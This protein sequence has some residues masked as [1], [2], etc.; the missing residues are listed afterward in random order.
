MI[1]KL[2]S[3]VSHYLK[4]THSKMD[5][6]GVMFLLDSTYLSNSGRALAQTC[7]CLAIAKC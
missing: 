5:L 4:E 7:G 6:W 1:P 2:E 3:K